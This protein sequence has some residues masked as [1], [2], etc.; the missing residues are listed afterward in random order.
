MGLFGS[1]SDKTP[2]ELPDALAQRVDDLLA[3]DDYFAAIRLVRRETGAGLVV[4]TRAVDHR[5]EL[6]DS[7]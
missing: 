2:L 3:R 4:G 1:A 5:K 6:R 7:A